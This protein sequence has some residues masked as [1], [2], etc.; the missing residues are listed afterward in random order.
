MTPADF[1]EFMQG[2]AEHFGLLKH[3]TFDTSVK[4]VNRNK[5]DN[6]WDVQVEN[7]ESGQTDTRHFDKVAFCHGYQTLKKMPIF[8]GQ[9]HYKGDLMHAQ[10]YRRFV[11]P[12][13]EILLRTLT[14]R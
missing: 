10:Q 7:V 3:I 4:V 9:D 12:D 11:F 6:G 2:Y 8:P 5:E 13:R 14:A 1:Q